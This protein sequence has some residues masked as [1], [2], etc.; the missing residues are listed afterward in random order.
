MYSFLE[1]IY[2]ISYNLVMNKCYGQGPK[3]SWLFIR[4]FN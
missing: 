3:L 1:L 2:F 4:D